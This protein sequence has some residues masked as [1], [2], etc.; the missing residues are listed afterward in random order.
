[1]KAPSMAAA[2]AL[3]LSIPLASFDAEAWET[4]WVLW[5]TG[6]GA[7]GAITGVA[8]AA[9][10]LRKR[11]GLLVLTATTTVLATFPWLLEW[12]GAATYPYEEA[13]L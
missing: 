11:W 1:M 7:L 12:S 2:R 6:M 13:K 4:R 9:M 8:G 5:S 3:A 10:I